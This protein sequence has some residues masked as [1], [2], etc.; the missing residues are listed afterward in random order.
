[1]E[2]SSENIENSSLCYQIINDW[3][4]TRYITHTIIFLSV[5]ILIHVILMYFILLNIFDKFVKIY[6]LIFVLFID[7]K[8]FPP[9][10][11]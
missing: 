6:L 1:M 5:F 10:I 9:L 11:Y 7:I 4:L 3:Y 8:I 2:I